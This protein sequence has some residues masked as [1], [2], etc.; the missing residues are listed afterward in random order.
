MPNFLGVPKSK[1]CFL[2]FFDYAKK[3]TI[4]I[5]AIEAIVPSAVS[6]TKI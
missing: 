6:S 1:V 2:S 5:E 4:P 3:Y